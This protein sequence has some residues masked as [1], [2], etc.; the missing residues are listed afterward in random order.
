[1]PRNCDGKSLIVRAGLV[2][3]SAGQVHSLMDD[4]LGK[5]IRCNCCTEGLEALVGLV[6]IGPGPRGPMMPDPI[7]V[8]ERQDRAEVHI[9]PHCSCIAEYKAT[10]A[11]G[12][13]LPMMS[14]MWRDKVPVKSADLVERA[15]RSSSTLGS[16]PDS[17]RKRSWT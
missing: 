15:R 7:A 12:E 11:E 9:V 17:D 13:S 6:V 10:V 5:R 4:V 2:I 8:V 16:M 3:G 14:W 1:M